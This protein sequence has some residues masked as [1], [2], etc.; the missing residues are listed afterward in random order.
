MT[1]KELAGIGRKVKE[2]Q[3]KRK[4][5]NRAM[6]SQWR[7]TGE[8]LMHCRTCLGISRQKMA[9]TMNCSVPVITRLEEGRPV[10]RRKLAEKAYKLALENINFQRER[11]LMLLGENES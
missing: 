7:R 3:E 9:E 6:A 10:R 8:M 4:E 1:E 2:M 11:H 5:Y